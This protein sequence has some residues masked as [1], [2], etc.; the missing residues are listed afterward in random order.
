VAAPALARL[1]EDDDE[2][3][4]KAVAAALGKMGEEAAT[5]I[6][7]FV[8]MLMD[9]IRVNEHGEAELDE[10]DWARLARA[11]I[12]LRT[13]GAEAKDEA[14]TLI[15]LAE[16]KCG[17]PRLYPSCYVAQGAAADTLERFGPDSAPMF[18]EMLQDPEISRR[19][20]AALTL[21]R[22]G[23]AASSAVPSLV[24]MLYSENKALSK[25]AAMG[26]AGIG[27]P[28]IP[29]LLAALHEKKR[30]VR[31]PAVRA[32]IKMGPKAASARSKLE[33]LAKDPKR[34]TRRGAEDVLHHL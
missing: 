26:L 32:L 4:R 25:A 2:D 18:I 19:R 23:P 20:L 7:R 16:V 22:L 6:A 28:A 13:I 1:V 31:E 11:T 17:E 33:E 24:E 34:W 14:R 8:G 9:R 27:E 21:G 3:V 12:I 15:R 29:P 30:S 5:P 10:A